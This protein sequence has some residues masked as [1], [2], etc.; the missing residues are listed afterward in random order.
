MSHSARKCLR[1]GDGGTDV[2]YQ[3]KPR[4]EIA[5]NV[6]LKRVNLQLSTCSN[7]LSFHEITIDSITN[8]NKILQ[9]K[10]VTDDSE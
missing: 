3:I 2:E 4:A 10:L 5:T 1:A 6:D 8:C 7:N 9:S